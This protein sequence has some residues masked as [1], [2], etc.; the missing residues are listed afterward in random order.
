[1]RLRTV[2]VTSLVAV[3]AAGTLTPALAAPKD[4]K[5]ITKTYTATAPTPDPTPIAGDICDPLLPS[6]KHEEPFTVPAAG[7]LKVTAKHEIDWALALLDGKGKR[8]AES[9]SS[10]LVAQ[11]AMQV[12]FKKKTDVVIRA[13]NFAGA[14]TAEITYVFTYA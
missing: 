3:A 1:M 5:P 6:A 10:D 14:P 9:D 11:E 4:K 8:L 2:A 12:K 7:T 13:C